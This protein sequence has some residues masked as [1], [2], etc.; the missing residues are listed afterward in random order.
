MNYLELPKIDLHCHLD[1]SLRPQTVID[2]AKECDI[3]IPSSNVDEI[4]DMMVAPASCPNLQE[5]LARFSLP[6]KVMQTEMSLERISFEL[7]EDAARE[8]V[9]YLEVRF[10]PQLHTQDGLNYQQI[11]ESVVRGM[12]KAEDKYDIKGN[13]ILSA[14]RFLPSDTINDVIDAGI[15]FIGHGVAAFDLAGNEDDGFCEKYVS[16]A[17]YAKE[18]GYRITIHAGEQGCGQNVLDAIELLGAE[19]IGHGVAIQSHD[20]AYDRVREDLV[21]LETCPSSN[22]QTK[23]VDELRE[24]PL[25]DFYQD[26]LAI[27]INTDN[28]TV[29]NTTMTKE[30]EKVMEMFKLSMDDYKTIYRSSVEQSFASDEVKQHLLTF[31]ESA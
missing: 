30:V 15:P 16:H 25:I 6:V 21:G 20:S 23:A 8:N 13:Y 26:N 3:E 19:R 7:F 1:G 22:V 12:K 24:H 27:T 14:V 10:A 17:Q 31:I 9:K 2:L 4:K 18:K 28:R 11:I 29:S 5:Y